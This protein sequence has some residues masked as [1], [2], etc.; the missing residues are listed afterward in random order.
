MHSAS[1]QKQSSAVSGRQGHT[2][3][4][5]L[6]HYSKRRTSA[7][8]AAAK[9]LGRVD[10]TQHEIVDA[11]VR[12]SIIDRLF[13]GDLAGIR[14]P[15]TVPDIRGYLDIA[16]R[17]ML[18]DLALEPSPSVQRCRLNAYLDAVILRDSSPNATGRDPRLLRRY[19][20]SVAANSA[21]V[22]SHKTIYD[23]AGINRCDSVR[24]SERY[25]SHA[26]KTFRA[27]VATGR[28]PFSTTSFRRATTTSARSREPRTVLVYR[29][30]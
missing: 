11:V 19:L 27:D 6:S 15:E 23:A 2:V 9:H 24:L 3:Q 21:G 14:F 26:A 13:A 10:F 12:S 5:M 16:M 1:S 22:P 4:V 8:V 20:A 17:C 29:R 25:R 18:P 28:S 7:D 30:R